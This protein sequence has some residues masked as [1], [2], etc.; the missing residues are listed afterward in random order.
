MADAN[1]V[2]APLSTACMELL[3]D[4]EVAAKYLSSRM[5]TLHNCDGDFLF[6]VSAGI[7]ALDLRTL[8]DVHRLRFDAGM[9][10]GQ[11]EA[12][13]SLRR[14]IGVDNAIAEATA[15]AGRD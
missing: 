2:S 6:R 14:F 13:A 10:A 15:E 12:F 1:A 3:A 4:R 9:V 5:V 8:L 11:R 7:D